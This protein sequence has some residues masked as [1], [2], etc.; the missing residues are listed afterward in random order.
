MQQQAIT[1]THPEVSELSPYW[2][3]A[4]ALI[5]GTLEMREKGE[6]YLPRWPNEEKDSYEKRLACATLLPAFSETV[7]NMTGRVFRAPLIPQDNV[8]PKV[9][10]ILPEFDGQGRS[11]DRFAMEVFACALAAGS[12]GILVDMPY[13][14]GATTQADIVAAGARPYAVLIEPDSIINWRI[15]K[16]GSI[17]HLR[18]YETAEEPDGDFNVKSIKQIRALWPGRFEIHRKNDKGEWVMHQS[19][20]M[21]LDVIPY[22]P[23]VFGDDD[24]VVTAKPKMRDLMHLNIEHWQSKSDQQTILHVA[25]VPVLTI[26]GVEDDAFKL[27]IGASTATKLPRDSD[28]KYV[29]HSGSSIEAGRNSLKDLEE[30]MRQAGAQL[31]KRTEISLTESQARDEA[32]R[33]VAPLAN[34]AKKLEDALDQTLPLFAKWLGEADGGNIKVGADLDLDLAPPESLDVLLKAN[35]AGKISDE[36]LFNELQRRGAI[37]DDYDWET[38][39][40]RLQMQA[41]ALGT[42]TDANGQRTTA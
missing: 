1:K 16:N 26:I 30:Q 25:R 37:S 32:S 15:G 11:V 5:G 42:M 20:A 22:V 13:I 6:L 28:M 33:L 18:F 17:E 34:M 27:K 14:E 2:A 39:R 38:E 31:L 36:T 35:L 40:E 4:E 23:V 19:G 3:M 12:A 41:P 21:S 8:P 9:A 29:E 10:A 24:H 7:A